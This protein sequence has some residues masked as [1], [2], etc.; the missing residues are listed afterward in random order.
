MT[1]QETV[2]QLDAHL[3]RELSSREEAAVRAH[4]EACASCA[5]YLATLRRLRRVLENSFAVTSGSASSSGFRALWERIVA[6]D[7][8]APVSPSRAMT[9]LARGRLRVG[10]APVLAGALAAGLALSVW[11][12]IG[13]EPAQPVAS[14]P[15]RDLLSRGEPEIDRALVRAETREVVAQAPRPV[16]QAAVRVSPKAAA[17]APRAKGEEAVA[18]GSDLEPPPDL[19]RRAELFLDYPI[20]RRLEELEHFDEVMAQGRDG[21]DRRG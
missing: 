5:S 19:L 9:G 13:R 10:R 21:R 20:V 6:D 1:C 16:E 18:V 4:L 17:A 14:G 8:T 3:D 12:S 15:N 7:G 2:Q 11:F